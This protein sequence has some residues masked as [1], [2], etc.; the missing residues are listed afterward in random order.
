[1]K[2]MNL[3]LVK[4]MAASVPACLLFSGSVVLFVRV[5]TPWCFLQLI[6]AGCL[7]LVVL[8]HICEAF[9]LFQLMHWGLEHSPGHYVDFWSAAVAVTCFPLGYLL[10]TLKRRVPLPGRTLC[11]RAD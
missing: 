10:D 5:R 6:G 4:A 8:T 2:T 1:M 9:G 7:L 11:R 3:T